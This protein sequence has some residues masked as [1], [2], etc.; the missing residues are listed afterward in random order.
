MYTQEIDSL[1]QLCLKGLEGSDYNVR[2]S[3]ATLWGTLLALS[4]QPLP[5]QHK[6]K[7]KCDILMPFLTGYY[8]RLNS[9]HLMIFSAFSL[10][11]LFEDQAVF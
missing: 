11:D 2:C 9:Q 1:S 5:P 8:N 6:G 7:V 4:Q 10:M 3:I